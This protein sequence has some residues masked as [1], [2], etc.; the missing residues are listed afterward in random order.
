MLYLAKIAQDKIV[1]RVVDTCDISNPEVEKGVV[2]I[3]VGQVAR[4]SRLLS[5]TAAGN[6]E[7][8]KTNKNVNHKL[9]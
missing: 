1:C 4:A 9:T 5:V 7:I 3:A 2:P 8:Q 6:P